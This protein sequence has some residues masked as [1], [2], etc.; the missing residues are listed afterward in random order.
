MQSRLR[1]LINNPKKLVVLL[2]WFALAIVIEALMLRHI[3]AEW[4]AGALAG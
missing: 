2:K 1:F 4:I 3:P